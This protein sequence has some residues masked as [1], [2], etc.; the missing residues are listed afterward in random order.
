V[1]PTANRVDRA[2]RLGV[3]LVGDVRQSMFASGLRVVAAG[4]VK[5]T[6][7]TRSEGNPMAQPLYPEDP[8]RPERNVD[9]AEDA[10]SFENRLE[11]DL[12]KALAA[13]DVPADEIEWRIKACRDDPGPYWADQSLDVAVRSTSRCARSRRSAQSSAQRC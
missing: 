6:M 13:V 12:R 10:E 4:G 1:S 11:A 3:L 7:L 8:E 5:A 2:P 9:E